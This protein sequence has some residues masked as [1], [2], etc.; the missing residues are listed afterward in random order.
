VPAPRLSLVVPSFDEEKRI[1]AALERIG[2]F[3]AGLDF[4][5]EVVVVDDGSREPGKRANEQALASLPQGVQGRLIKHDVNRGKGAAVRTGCLAAAGEYV[6]F[7]DADL[8]TP[9]EDL[10]SLLKEL[11]GGADVGA[12]RGE[13]AAICEP[14]AAA[15]QAC[16]P[17]VR[18][19]LRIAARYSDSQCL[20]KA[21][22]RPA[23]QRL[24]RLQRIDTWSFDARSRG[25]APG[26]KVAKVPVTGT[27]S[28]GHLSSPPQRDELWNLAFASRIGRR[29]RR[30]QS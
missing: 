20:L 17:T 9:P 11:D 7:I 14:T 21:F 24:F 16:R 25:E 29:R 18:V 10:L 13:M 2:S 23:A 28:K 1:G 5:S 30:C 3:L 4:P 6:A 27:R 26:L 8:A 19:R 12:G 22:R 15:A